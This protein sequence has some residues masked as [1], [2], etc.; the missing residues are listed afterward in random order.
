MKLTIK[1]DMI[2][3]HQKIIISRKDQDGDLCS[4]YTDRE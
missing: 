3:N 2:Q 1:V 4:P